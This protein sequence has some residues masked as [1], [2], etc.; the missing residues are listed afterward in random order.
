MDVKRLAEK[1]EAAQA[2]LDEIRKESG[3]EMF[4]E[5]SV[6]PERRQETA[7]ETA[8]RAL[9]E[10]RRRTDH[11]GNEKIFG[12]PAWD[13]LLDLFIHQVR[14]EEVTVKRATVG[15]GASSETALRW[16]RVLDQEG[17]VCFEAD[18]VEAD[19][20]LLHLT[21]EGYESITR[22]LEEISR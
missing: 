3:C 17:L 16:L 14:N 20:C 19:T 7:L 6:L 4:G 12:E 22:Y 15:S 5:R 18:P 10:R 13:I 11:F 9:T 8:E 2:I 21:P 1:I